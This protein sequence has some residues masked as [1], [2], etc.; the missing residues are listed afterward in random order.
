MTLMNS[1]RKF[2]TLQSTVANS[3]RT[4]ICVTS[5]YFGTQCHL[6][7]ED[8]VCSWVDDV[9]GTCYVLD[10]VP[11]SWPGRDIATLC[12]LA[13]VDVEFPC[14]E[15]RHAARAL[16]CD[17]ITCPVPWSLLSS[18]RMFRRDVRE[19]LRV[20][21]N[22]L[23]SPAIGYYGRVFEPSRRLLSS[24]VRPMIDSG[25]LDDYRSSA[26]ASYIDVLQSFKPAADGS[27]DQVMY[28]VVGGRTGRMHVVSGPQI[29]RLR[30]K[31]RDIIR[32]RF[33]G[34]RVVLVDFVSLEA[35]IA[36][37]EAGR[38]PSADVYSSIATATDAPR[39]ILKLATLTTLFGGSA[40]ATLL[41]HVDASA[42][43]AVVDD[44]TEYFDVDNVT[45]RLVSSSQ[46]N[47]VTT[48]MGRVVRCPDVRRLYN[49][50]VQGTGVEVA[51]TGFNRLANALHA[52]E[53]QTCMMFIIHDAAVIDVHP[54][55]EAKFSTI[56]ERVSSHCDCYDVGFPLK[57]KELIE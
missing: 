8:D 31:H 9:P 21:Q 45:S 34:G 27:A 28:D 56:V 36:A 46:S 17:G 49:S 3:G 50:Y 47:T 26:E 5:R 19:L 25:K 15:L 54:S 20:V 16:N 12:Q 39:H 43:H 14:A 51:A 11:G 4:S 32:T 29:L 2:H 55:E 22:V 10:T 13:A 57:I 23:R 33:T 7:I 35:R 42:A 52:A 48:K 40:E 41:Q 18:P 53:M 38:T 37:I 1:D 6:L 30:R 44:V 24:L